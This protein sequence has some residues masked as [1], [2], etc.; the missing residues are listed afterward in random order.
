ME[1]IEGMT[2][3]N[4][5]SEHAQL[6][7]PLFVRGENVIYQ[8]LFDDGGKVDRFFIRFFFAVHACALRAD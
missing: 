3:Q 1:K 2:L 7:F 8:T 5:K 4:R 6:L